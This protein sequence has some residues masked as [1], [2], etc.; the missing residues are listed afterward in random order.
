MVSQRLAFSQA[1]FLVVIV[2]LPV[3]CEAQAA[4]AAAVSDAW[5]ARVADYYDPRALSELKKVRDPSDPKAF[6][7][8]LLS[9]RLSLDPAQR[10]PTRQADLV[11]LLLDYRPVWRADKVVIA[12]WDRRLARI[13]YISDEMTKTWTP[14]LVTANGSQLSE[15]WIIGLVI[16]ADSLF[17]DS[18]IDGTRANSLVG[19]LRAL[20]PPA[21]ES[22]A[23]ALNLV[24][25]WA[26]MLL[27]Q[28]DDLFDST[29][30]F[31]QASFDSALALV[32]GRLPGAK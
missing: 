17:T 3:T 27:I 14:A 10:S 25:A 13:E 20:P 11:P 8:L 19:R 18:G 31:R 24:R 4:S 26:A 28:N 15:I 1:L 32:V 30:T 5:A 21:I 22:L 29:G 9:L 6:S 23:K 7:Y 16:D 2:A 12:E